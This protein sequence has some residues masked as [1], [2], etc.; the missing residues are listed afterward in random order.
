MLEYIYKSNKFKFISHCTKQ[1]F[2]KFLFTLSNSCILFFPVYQESKIK[3]SFS[4]NT[5]LICSELC[6]KVNNK[7][8]SPPSNGSKLKILKISKI[9]Y[10]IINKTHLTYNRLPSYIT[11]NSV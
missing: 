10:Y 1:T 3:K 4:K 5:F 11:V 2:I 6:C 8:F 9:N 7:F